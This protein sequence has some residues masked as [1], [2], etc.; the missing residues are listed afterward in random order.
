MQVYNVL[1]HYVRDW[2]IFSASSTSSCRS[3]NCNS[4][5]Q[6]A[7]VTTLLWFGRPS[8]NVVI[9]CN[10]TI[11]KSMLIICAFRG[12]WCTHTGFWGICNVWLQCFVSDVIEEFIRNT[13][14]LGLRLTEFLAQGLG[15]SATTFSQHFAKT[16]IDTSF[17]RMN[18]YPPC[19][20]PSKTQ[21][22]GPHAD[23]NIFTL[24]LQDTV[25]GL[26]ILKGNNW[27]TIPP[28]PDAFV[29][30]VGDGLQ[31]SN[32]SFF[33]PFSCIIIWCLRRCSRIGKSMISLEHSPHCPRPSI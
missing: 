21:G 19:P 18:Y 30:N 8:F 28:H 24:L 5:E 20:T 29:V 14:R 7:N 17:M 33:L 13:N 32:S 10:W 4:T 11:M 9:G 16:P 12:V 1:F 31:A 15:L 2:Y 26:Q 22:I 6:R 27:I 3:C 25:P 23:F